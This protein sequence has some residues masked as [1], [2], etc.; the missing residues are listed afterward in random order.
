M[1]PYS[2]HAFTHKHARIKIY[3]YTV[4]KTTVTTFFFVEVT[5]TFPIRLKK[6]RL[7]VQQRVLRIDKEGV[8]GAATEVNPFSRITVKINQY[9]FSWRKNDKT[10][11]ANDNIIIDRALV[12]GNNSCL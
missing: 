4:D 5:F 3:I 6:H 12:A 2:L 9:I 7:E 11:D 10:N 1:D 8:R